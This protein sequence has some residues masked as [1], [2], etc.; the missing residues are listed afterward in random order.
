MP[1]GIGRI[2]FMQRGHRSLNWMPEA[3][4]GFVGLAMAVADGFLAFTGERGTASPLRAHWDLIQSVSDKPASRARRCH[5]AFVSSSI[6]M[7]MPSLI[8]RLYLLYLQC[9]WHCRYN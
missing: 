9:Q 2:L 7:L 3:A 4:T 6:R 1:M 5:S 8:M